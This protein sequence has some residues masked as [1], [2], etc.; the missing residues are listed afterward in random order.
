MAAHSGGRRSPHATADGGGNGRGG[1]QSDAIANRL[2]IAFCA[3]APASTTSMRYSRACSSAM[4]LRRASR[5]AVGV[6]SSPVSCGRLMRWTTRGRATGAMIAN[7][8]KCP[9]DMMRSTVHFTGRKS[10]LGRPTASQIAAVSATS[11]LRRRTYGLTLDGGI[12]RAWCPNAPI[13]QAQ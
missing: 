6:S 13:R 9:C 3:L 11:V 4:M 8:A 10:V 12:S 5:A 1:D 2:L 7:S